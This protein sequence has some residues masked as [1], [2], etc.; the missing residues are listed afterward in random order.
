M[1]LLSLT[2]SLQASALGLGG[3][4]ISSS[5]NQP[6][7]AEIELID[8]GALSLAEIKA[9]LAS[10]AEYERIG[11]DQSF[12]SNKL[13]FVVERNQ[14]NKP[15]IKIRSSA[16]ISDPFIQILV[17][18]AWS[19]GQ[20]YREY[21]VLLD[22]KDYNLIVKKTS[23]STNHKLVHKTGMVDRPIY[24]VVAHD[25]SE[26]SNN[27]DER[28]TQLTSSVK[29]SADSPVIE[30]IVPTIPPLKAIKYFI[31]EIGSF[32]FA[33]EDINPSNRTK[34]IVPIKAAS[35]L[36]SKMDIART[37]ID[38]INESNSLLKEQLHMMQEQNKLLINQL[39]Q[40]DK[41][42]DELSEQVML[43]MRRQGI[44]GKA[45]Q[46]GNES[47]SNGYW[48]WLFFLLS[49]AGGTYFAWCKWGEHWK[50]DFTSETTDSLEKPVKS[51]A[52]LY[53]LLSL[54]Q[55]YIDIGDKNA[56]RESLQEV[57]DHGSAMQKKAAQS[58]MDITHN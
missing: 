11:L 8:V 24:Q 13:T 50:F 31:P 20:V 58:L 30:S 7:D 44:A 16:R 53:T 17:D 5:L 12:I 36:E 45:I 9:S 52:A 56:A 19:K 42:M 15:V 18:L 40:P 14:Q 23:H 3:I 22:P 2:V 32:L 28:A 54:A 55:T 38:S 4:T 46:L 43:L 34:I 47:T 41:K 26:N 57:I 48:L 21:S 6:F 33:G 25:S 37:A 1:A 27:L 35:T 10:V 39:K 51:E 29:S 49:A